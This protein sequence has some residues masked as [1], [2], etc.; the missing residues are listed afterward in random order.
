MS[1][2]PFLVLESTSTPVNT[3]SGLFSD[4]FE[5]FN[6]LNYSGGTKL[7]GSSNTGGVYDAMDPLDGLAKSTH[8]NGSPL[9]TRSNTKATNTNAGGAEANK[10][11]MK[12]SVNR[13]QKKVDTPLGFEEN[14]ETADDAWLKFAE[15]PHFKQ[16]A[17]ASPPRPLPPKRAQV[18]KE[19]R[20][21]LEDFAMGGVRKNAMGSRPS[22]VPRS[23]ATTVDSLFETQFHNVG[24]PQVARSTSSGAST[25][26]KKAPS[27]TSVDDLSLIFFGAGMSSEVFEEVE[28]ESEERRR[29]R[30]ERHQRTQERVAKAVSEKNQ[31]DLQTQREQEERHRIAETLNGEIKRWAAG[32]EGNLRALLSTLHLVLGTECGWQPVSLTDMITSASVKKVFRKAN[33]CIHPDKVQ[34]KGANLRQKCIAEKVFD[35]LQEAWNKFNSEELS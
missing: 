9:R 21:E 22:S 11:S 14:L 32:K 2:D 27:M 4:P 30:M 31:R 3:S 28:G 24:G 16:P 1:E 29:A 35:V 19:D 25:G 15:I 26:M 5:Q 20:D 17:S 7:D 6:H 13:L 33:L 23:R 18:S 34:Q 12:T 8:M 10:A